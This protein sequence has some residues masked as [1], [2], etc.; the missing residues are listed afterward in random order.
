MKLEQSILE[1]KFY[2]E[3]EDP[4]ND[5]ITID[6]SRFTIGNVLSRTTR[7]YIPSDMI[8]KSNLSSEEKIEAQE[9]VNKMMCW[10]VCFIGFMEKHAAGNRILDKEY[11]EELGITEA[12][13]IQA[14]SEKILA[15]RE[16]IREFYEKAGESIAFS[17]NINE[18]IPK[19]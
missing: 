16:K 11:A 12:A 5:R 1:K 14:V 17:V 2:Y 4:K 18:L 8:Q 9:A 13:L 15:Y 10:S 6:Y 3:K 19:K 7:F